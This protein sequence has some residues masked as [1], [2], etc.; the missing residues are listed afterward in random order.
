MKTIPLRSLLREPIKVK[1]LTRSG[2]SVQVTDNGKPLWVIQPAPQDEEDP[3][4]ARAIDE[5]LDE[6][7][8]AP[9]SKVSLSEILERERR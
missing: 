1:R 4:R 7:L 6:A 8:R 9:R 5:L 2:Q 3:E